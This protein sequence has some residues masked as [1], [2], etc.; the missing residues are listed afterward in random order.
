MPYCRMLLTL[1][2]TAALASAAC[3]SSAASLQSALDSAQLAF[4]MMDSGAFQTATGE[5][6]SEASCLS[7]P[8]SPTVAAR[9]HRVLGLRAFVAGDEAAARTAFAAARAIEPDYLFPASLVPADHPVRAL[10]SQSLNASAATTE[11]PSPATGHLQFD[12]SQGTR[13]P[14]QRPTL[15]LLVDPSGAVKGSG[16]LW[17]D[18]PVFA[19]TPASATIATT[20]QAPKSTVRRGPNLPLTVIAAVSLAAGGACYGIAAAA[21]KD[22]EEAPNEEPTLTAL[23]GKTNTFFFTSIGAGVVALGTGVGA[24]VAGHW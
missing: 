22:Y 10:Y 6:E 17:P 11:L 19:Y 3:P 9:L 12:G 24:V 2:A 21:H 16:Y 8:V 1:L 20:T 23:Q 14:T 7:D 15:A 5:A 18:D 13:R 4:S